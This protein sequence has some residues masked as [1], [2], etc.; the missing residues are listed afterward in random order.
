MA[1]LPERASFEY[2]K[3]LVKDRLD[4]LC[5][6]DPDA[7]FAAAQ[8]AVVREYGFSSWRALKAAMDRRQGGAGTA[9]FEACEKGD[10]GILSGRLAKDPTL[11]RA[12]RVDADSGGWTGL[13]S[14]AQA[15]LEV[16]QAALAGR[17]ADGFEFVEDIYDPPYGKRQ[18][19]IPRSEGIYIV[20]FHA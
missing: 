3:K 16:A 15:G 11:V 5:Q 20:F 9:F 1:E 17:R 14:A 10:I 19:G 12:E 8:L 18:F 7:I 13:H 4:E 2:L 6:L